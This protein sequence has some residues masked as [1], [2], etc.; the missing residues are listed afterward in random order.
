VLHKSVDNL[1]SNDPNH[2]NAIFCKLKLPET[3]PSIET[4]VH[5]AKR[6]VESNP[7]HLALRETYGSL[8]CFRST[9]T[10]QPNYALARTQFN[11]VLELDPSNKRNSDIYY[12]RGLAALFDNDLLAATR[13]LEVFL[14]TQPQSARKYPEACYYLA[15]VE[16]GKWSKLDKTN[17]GFASE[18]TNKEIF[19][20]I[21]KLY[22]QGKAAED[23]VIRLPIF[24]PVDIPP[25]KLL[26]IYIAAGKKSI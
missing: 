8:L 5:V 26:P 13:D 3:N 24:D 25:K 12:L 14:N 6:G 21:E 2:G 4:Y 23:D 10:L 20:K 11:K 19:S 17:S 22:E 16:F 7:K 18:S 1:L 15:L 9:N